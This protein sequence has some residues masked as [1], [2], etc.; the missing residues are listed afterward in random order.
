MK[1]RIVATLLAT[2]ITA[3]MIF[4]GCGSSAASTSR[5]AVSS[6]VSS[7]EEASSGASRAESASS[8]ASRTESASSEASSANAASEGAESSETDSTRTAQMSVSVSESDLFTE[9]DLLQTADT[10]DAKTLTA[11]DGQTL[12]ITEA[13]VYVIRGTAA[14]CTIRVEAADS[15]K[16]QLVLDNVNITNDSAPAIYVVSA[17][18]VFVTTA[19]GTSNTLEVTGTFAADGETNTDAVIFAKDDLVL[20][21]LGSLTINSTDNGISAKD[22]LK[23]TGGTYVI[24]AVSD[25]VETNDSISICGG[26][27]TITSQKDGLHCENDEDQTQGSIYISGGTFDIDVKSDAV[28]ATTTLVIDGGTFH[29]AGK[30]A[31]EATNITINDGTLN[32]EATDDGINASQKSTAEDVMININGGNITIDMGAGDTDA[33]DANGSIYINGGTLSINAQSAFDY[34]REGTISEAADVTVNGQKVTEMTNQFGGGGFGGGFGRQ[35]GRGGAADGS[36]TEGTKPGRPEGGFGGGS[37]R[38]GRFGDQSQSGS[39]EGQ[40][41]PEGFDGQTPPEGFDGQTPPEG[42]DGRFPGGQDGQN[43]GS[44]QNQGQPVG[45]STAIV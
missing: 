24:E 19:E 20:N 27:F 23:V 16:V 4:V 8:G 37:G 1:R 13:G 32:I 21:G 12:S 11:A 10:A 38:R 6:S 3:S 40:T 41:P 31:L 45:G 22:D 5:A 39:T 18:K 43:G 26:D 35:G 29:L 14:N 36:N 15:D 44:G 7:S 25:A 42:F 17:D 33:I 30:E 28:Q 34:D 2:T 9:R